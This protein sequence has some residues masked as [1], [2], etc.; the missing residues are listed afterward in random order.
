MPPPPK[1]NVTQLMN[2]PYFPSRPGMNLQPKIFGIFLVKLSSAAISDLKEA[3][4]EISR[5]GHM[6][7][8]EPMNGF[9]N[10]TIRLCYCPPQETI[11]EAHLI[12]LENITSRPAKLD[13]M[14]MCR[15]HQ[16]LMT[17]TITN[18]VILDTYICQTNTW[19]DVQTAM[20]GTYENRQRLNPSGGN[21][22]AI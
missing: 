20:M 21:K 16:V 9:C 19:E 18:G 11:A 15:H 6:S 5:K 1:S 3:L 17:T 12:I 8:Q 2:F 22:K 7:Y 14:E 13:L 4:S 10:Q